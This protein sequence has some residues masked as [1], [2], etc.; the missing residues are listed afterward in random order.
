MEL[1][2]DA[3]KLVD[4]KSTESISGQSAAPVRGS[5]ESAANLVFPPLAAFLREFVVKGGVFKGVRGLQSSF[6]AW[7]LCFATEAK[8]YEKQHAARP[9]VP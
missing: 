9:D 5:L 4:A 3:V 8:R 1:Q 6:N 7:A 2:S